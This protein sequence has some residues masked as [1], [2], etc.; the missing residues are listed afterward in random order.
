MAEIEFE[1]GIWNTHPSHVPGR[2][3][4]LQEG[5][6][7]SLRQSR[8]NWKRLQRDAAAES[9]RWS[10]GGDAGVQPVTAVCASPFAPAPEG[11]GRCGHRVAGIAGNLSPGLAHAAAGWPHRDGTV[12]ERVFKNENKPPI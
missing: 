9:Q 3:E 12:L 8:T 1:N 2:F 11:G 7:P 4:G 10:G 5:A 6:H